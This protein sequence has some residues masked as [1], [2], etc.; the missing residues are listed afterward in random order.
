MFITNFIFL[1]KEKYLVYNYIKDRDMF[2][3][4][5]MI[6]KL[7]LEEFQQLRNQIEN[8]IN[9]IL[10]Y[11]NVHKNDDNFDS[12][13]Y[14]QEMLEQI[15]SLQNNLLSYDLSDIPFEAWKGFSIFSDKDHIVDFSKTK[16]N[17]DFE[18]VNYTPDAENLNY[19]FKGCNIRNLYIL[20]GERLIPDRFDEETIKKNPSLFLTDIFS[21]EI[22]DR[23]YSHSLTLDDLVTLSNEQ[24]SEI[25]QKNYN[26]NRWKKEINDKL[27]ETFGLDK[28]IELIKYS[29]EDY[30]AI[31]DI[32]ESLK[33]GDFI[34]SYWDYEYDP[35]FLKFLESVKNT[36]FSKLKNIFYDFARDILTGKIQIDNFSG[37]QIINEKIFPEQFVKENPDLFLININVPDEVKN[38]FFEKKLTYQD[39]INYMEEFKNV[40][41]D[42]FTEFKNI[43][44]FVVNNNYDIDEFHN[45]L[46]RH[47]DLFLHISENH[48]FSAFFQFFKQGGDL[49]SVFTN[50]VKEY[51]YKYSMPDD[52]RIVEADGQVKFN[53]PDWLSS[54]NFKFV[55]KINTS[56]ELL[57]CDGSVFVIDEDQRRVLD[58]LNIQN[59]KRFEQETGFF[60]H[61]VYEWSK[62][63][64]MFNLF[65]LYLK[66]HNLNS[67]GIDFKN[68]NL[69]YED[70]LDQ[71]AKCLDNM[72]K[73]NVFSDYPNYDWIQGEFRNAH[74]EIFIDPNAP[75]ELKDAF[76]KN[77]ITPDFLFQQEKYIPYLVDKNLS[78][79]LKV[80]I[81]IILPGL[82]NEYSLL[83]N[84]L[85]FIDEY[86]S[87]YGN[88]K[89]LKLITEYGEMLS[90]IT[91][92]SI[93]NEIEDEQ[94]IKKSLRNS[95]YKK[96]IAGKMNY[97]YL[98]NIPEMVEEY[99]DIFVNFDSLTNIPQEERVRLT[100]AFYN[101]KF[102]FNDI[103]KYP[104]LVSILKDKNLLIAFGS[105]DGEH[106]NGRIIIPSTYSRDE[107]YSDL[108]LLSVFGN[109][110]FLQLCSKY[111]RYLD[112]ITQYLNK[113]VTIKD[114]KYI[115]S[116]SG[117]SEE[118]TI[119]E[120]E[121]R[122]I[123]IIKK[124][125]KR[126]NIDYLP[127]DAP[128]FLKE[129]HPELFLSD[130]APEELKNYFYNKQH[131]T[132]DV[133][134][135][136]K[137]WL[138][139][140][141]GK[142]IV[143]PLLRANILKKDL[144]KFI[145]IFGEEKAIKLGINRSETVMEMIKS[146]QVDLM[147]KWYDK[148]GGKFIPD[149]VVMQNF[150]IEEADKFLISGSNWSNL[151][152]I[153]SFAET[154]ES[155]DAM[156][157]LAYSF[158][159][160]DQDKR[161]F[162]KLQDLLT[163][164]PRTINASYSHIIES[165][166]S[167]EKLQSED[168]FTEL[169]GYDKYIKLGETLSKEGF[170]FDSGKNLISQIYRKNADG[171]YSLTINPQSYPK[172]SQLIRSIMEMYPDSPILTP[173]KAHKFFGGFKM[174][175]NPD[176]R[177]FFLKNY[178]IIIN[179]SDYLSKISAVQRRFNEIKTVYSNVNLTL[180]L[181]VSYIDSNRYEK[182]NVGN[183][184]VAT[185]A[186]VQNYS[187]Q[188][189]ETLQTIYNYGKQRTFSSIPRVESKSEVSL[190][191]G[192]YYYE[193]L[194]LDDPRAMSI[195]FESDCCQRLSEPAELCMEHSM[196][197]KN[198][199]VFVI[200]NK[201][202]EI[203]AQ[204]WVWRN[205][206]VLCF[207]NIEI[208]DQKMWD[209]GVPRGKEDSGIRNQFTDD[210]LS[211]YKM[212]ASELITKDEKIYKELLESGKITK[213]QYDG[214]RLGK[215]TTGLGY[216][217]IKGSLRTLPIDN[218]AI[219]RPL[220]FYEPV[221]LSKGL[222]INDSTT[223]FILEER[224]DR[225]KIDGETL[226]VHSDDYIEYND[227][228]FTE[229]S[230]HS[231][232]KLE[233]ITKDNP[234]YLDTSID[235]EPEK[236]EHIVSNIARNYQLNPETTRIVMNPNFAIIY[237]VNNNKLKI[238][239]LLF[240]TKV[241]NDTQQLD[242][243]HAV[244]MQIKLALDQIANGKE[245]DIS[246]LSEKQQEMYEKAILLKDE[247]DKERGVG[248][249]R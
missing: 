211:I 36:E 95:I 80:E 31:N 19:N 212:V 222:Y 114:G 38:R 155:R 60:T 186:A 29:K 135:A 182:V 10:E 199:R 201:K 195:G 2:G 59:I 125:S 56:E 13:T 73:N 122:I 169:F 45:I 229:K 176:F 1:V 5:V 55:D 162:K 144:I 113:E 163:G 146:H 164:L 159:A 198:G 233:A 3:G 214:L 39:Y 215:I 116:S 86:A 238:G 236:L 91:I 67:L 219:S 15:F 58:T 173:T 69:T 183:E 76:Y 244:V 42:Y 230:L 37:T 75:K 6:K 154:R 117:K 141:K 92:S 241:D 16:A 124:E 248:H 129:S 115:D 216:S 111:G 118:L 40:P 81:K 106:K 102:Q 249:V 128:D 226:A 123:N 101:R 32:I 167:L 237:D 88:E 23:Y 218:S 94:A 105:K 77:R 140:L 193:M 174:E 71:L 46:Q 41:V 43:F 178:D 72:R 49:N 194:R 121:N 221:K 103:K 204:S 153:Q 17:I 89:L 187:Q 225:K 157:K 246:S 137:E 25:K 165:F 133:L 54:M 206:D 242:I 26:S 35:V 143:T 149:F 108:E 152:K 50:A 52:F 151:M 63:L 172:S 175:Y 48:E 234:R 177:E 14:Q 22:K 130:D 127:D 68:G 57:K 28:I 247:I 227:S 160:F 207:D 138:P 112:D 190:P 107:K 217:N 83:P 203:V 70:F 93:N 30:L 109:D 181:A 220:P 61:K 158:G 34:F 33:L 232:E 168:N 11:I 4:V 24:L 82:E 171:S 66:S 84:Y 213:E 79:T 126:G 85:D 235:D 131:L 21:E 145:E 209:N 87:R 18:L 90:N 185:A 223:Q 239:D 96:I 156:L 74:P 7:T 148:T 134:H 44:I 245:I 197:D 98:S 132:F 166:P 210:V 53:V 8:F 136:H 179:N 243:E 99:P 228:N 188:E 150:N 139:Y 78:N 65:G 51:F 184:R 100:N 240:N 170:S 120:I 180:D 97:S 191:T 192:S 62:D 47:S 119:D 208:P 9:Q 20:A 27:L 110:K 205:K 142:S 189:F 12:N 200:T 161:G 196:V 224:K 231:L 202:G 104:E 147:K 64:E